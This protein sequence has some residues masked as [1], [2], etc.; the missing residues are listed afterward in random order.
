MCTSRGELLVIK[1]AICLHE[2]DASILW[3]HTDRRFNDP[4]VGNKIGLK[5]KFN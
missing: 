1:N 4:E 5:N 2:E 3:K